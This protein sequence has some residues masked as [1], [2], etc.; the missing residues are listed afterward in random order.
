MAKLTRKMSEGQQT[1]NVGQTRKKEGLLNP[2]RT[3]KREM[4]FLLGVKMRTGW[5]AKRTEMRRRRQQDDDGVWRN[6]PTMERNWREVR[7]ERRSE[8]TGHALGIAWPHQTCPGGTSEYGKTDPED[9]RRV[10]ANQRWINAEE[11]G[12]FKPRANEQK[13]EQ[14]SPWSE[15]AYGPECRTGGEEEKALAG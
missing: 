11:G 1:I 3:N 6:R 14:F 10:A 15:D 13:G 5:S 8:Q 4:S 2:E 9:V 12:V 7:E